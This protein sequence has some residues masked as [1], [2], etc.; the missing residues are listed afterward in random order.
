M[1]LL[2]ISNTFAELKL[3][4]MKRVIIFI[5]L[6]L[7]VVDCLS[8]TVTINGII[9]SS[10]D[11]MPINNV[12]ISII[13]SKQWT[14]SNYKGE[15]VL[16]DVKLPAVLKVTHL[17]YLTQ[18]ISLSK[19]D[20]KKKNKINLDIKLVDKVSPLSEI[21]IREKPKNMLER[22]V[23]DFEVDSSSV[24][25]INNS[26]DKKQLQTYSFDDYLKNKIFIPDECNEMKY[27]YSN[28]LSVKN[29]ERNEYYKV[30]FN[31]KKEIK[32]KKYKFDAI[33]RGILITIED[34][35]NFSL[36]GLS[37][38]SYILEG[39]GPLFINTYI[40][41]GS[42]KNKFFYQYDW[43]GNRI[44]L[45][46]LYEENGGLKYSQL[47]YALYSVGDWLKDEK[48][49]YN[50]NYRIK[51]KFNNK[52]DS[53]CMIIN[54]NIRCLAYNKSIIKLN[55]LVS[56]L[57]EGIYTGK[58]EKYYRERKQE[59]PINIKQIGKNVYIFNFEKK[60][61][62]KLSETGFPIDE[63]KIDDNVV[64]DYENIEEIISNQEG[65][66]CFIRCKGVKTKL[67]EIDLKTGKYIRTINLTYSNVEK[68]RI[69]KNCIYY[70]ARAGGFNGFERWLYKETINDLLEKQPH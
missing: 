29:R 19:D 2:F 46:K 17:A 26:K 43:Y 31:K 62:Y 51:P 20:I 14:S 10:S 55:N 4:I 69:V 40:L 48:I 57:M 65:T 24:Y 60:V 38:K 50:I 1:F 67:K 63:I 41:K 3:I 37:V 54:D 5:L 36:K 15:F 59:I 33:E 28:I 45:F 27:D 61:I 56:G 53:I 66:R 42:S 34:A 9:L 64:N 11:G 32:L 16:K 25:V 52:Y 23:Y 7:Y 22:L 18:E 6:I 44:V 8:Q 35:K 68:I 12:N 47:Y 30:I 70:T 13:N 58:L 39:K 21:V 49:N